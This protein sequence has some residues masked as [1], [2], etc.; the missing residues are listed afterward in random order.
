MEA[1]CT[2]KLVFIVLCLLFSILIEVKTQ[3]SI[4]GVS[5]CED[6][7]AYHRGGPTGWP[8]I[9]LSAPHGGN[10][11]SSAI[12]DRDAGCWIAGERRCEYTH[13]CGSKNTTR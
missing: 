7:V 4:A 3:S 12:P 11:S 13:T 1:M 10:L 8:P 5:D 2:F 9:I 6:F